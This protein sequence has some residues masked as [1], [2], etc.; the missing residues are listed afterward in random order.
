[1]DPTEDR[2]IPPAVVFDKVSLS[3]TTI[4]RLVKR[5]QFPAPIPLTPGRHAWSAK[6][7]QAW[8]DEKK[9]GVAA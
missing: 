6:A 7:I 2:L 3:R 9:L 5:K 4:W 1:M 8:I